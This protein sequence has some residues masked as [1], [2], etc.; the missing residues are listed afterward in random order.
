MSDLLNT[1]IEGDDPAERMLAEIRAEEELGDAER[2]RKAGLA[3]ALAQHVRTAFAAAYNHR[4]TSLDYKNSLS[5][6]LL[7]CKRLYEGYYDDTRLASIKKAGGSQAYENIVAPK[8][9]DLVSWMLDIFFGKSERPYGLNPSP[10]Q[11][12]P[13]DAPDITPESWDQFI[14]D[15]QK[16]A[17]LKAKRMEKIIE[18]QLD[19]SQFDSAMADFFVNFAIYPYAVLKGP[20]VLHTEIYTVENGIGRVLDDFMLSQDNISP[21]DFYK[22]PFAR[23]VQEGYTLELANISRDDLEAQ[24]GQEGWNDDEINAVLEDELPVNERSYLTDQPIEN[25]DGI[26]DNSL[27]GIWMY[28]DIRG[29]KLIDWGA[30]WAT[31]P[32][33]WYASCVYLIGHH[34]VYSAANPDPMGRKPYYVS[35]FRSIP[36]SWCGIGLP[37]LIEEKQNA[38]NSAVRHLCTHLAVLRSPSPVIDESAIDKGTFNLSKWVPGDPIIFKS[39]KLH[40][41]GSAIKPVDWM[42]MPTAH[43]AFME[44]IQMFN[45]DL[46]NITLVP[47]FAHGSADMGGATNTMGGLRSLMESAARGI[48]TSINT[49]YRQVVCPLI[50]A[51]NRH[52]IAH[53][54]NAIYL[55]AKGDFKAQARGLVA[56][57]IQESADERMSMLLDQAI[58]SPIVQEI[59]GKEGIADML[60]INYERSNIGDIVPAKET[61]ER[62]FGINGLT[63]GDTSA[64]QQI[65]PP[66]MEATANVA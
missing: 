30:K 51:I 20:V 42:V 26:S 46:D 65:P 34:V 32:D 23:T 57:M 10:I 44:A 11:N 66:A 18:D 1:I 58:K 17:E 27:C 64:P 6:R 50:E 39:A 2:I 14:K 53:L 41:Q 21:F 4:N 16:E 36:G 61:I 49:I 43:T 38:I 55:S 52:N 59:I 40:N 9:Q 48:K 25:R 15:L 37:E 7:T 22:A 62:R 63:P 12:I 19:E 13:P 5:E 47:R 54:P 35:S 3:V 56:M 60:R 28:D 33:A 8:V 45:N 29:Q 24:R 31:D